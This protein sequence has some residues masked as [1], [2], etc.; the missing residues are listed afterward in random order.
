MNTQAA[1]EI[2]HRRKAYRDVIA[3][4][5]V[6]FAVAEGEIFGI[7][8][9]NGTG[10]TTTVECVLG[11]LNRGRPDRTPL[12]IFAATALP[13]VVAITTTGVDDKK[14]LPATAAA[15]VA[16]TMISVLVFPQV[17]TALLKRRDNVPHPRDPG[18]GAGAATTVRS[19][20]I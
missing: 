20:A 15:L 12:A 10:K 4:D 6:S 14:I 9:P 19:G 11:L 7:L 17:A 1:V 2:A 13:M 3:V 16:A 18:D 5:D 8:G